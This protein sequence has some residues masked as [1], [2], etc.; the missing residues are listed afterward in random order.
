M[1]PRLIAYICFFIALPL[2]AQSAAG[3]AGISGVVRDPSGASVPP[4][5]GRGLATRS[6]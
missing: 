4:P 5:W 1:N 2:F 6:P 3:L